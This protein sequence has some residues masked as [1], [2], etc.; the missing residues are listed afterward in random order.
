MI[1]SIFLVFLAGWVAWF[2]ID[3]PAVG[4]FGLPPVS[5]SLVEN[6]QRSFDLLKAGYPNMAYLYIWHAH[7]LILSVVFGMLLAVVFRTIYDH[8]ARNRR[9]RHYYPLPNA[10]TSPAVKKLPPERTVV[11]PDDDN[12]SVNGGSSD[13]LSR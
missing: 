2:W 10:G 7:Y 3:K 6:F 11:S 12:S 5:D 4:Q 9:R 8:L 13:H 1:K